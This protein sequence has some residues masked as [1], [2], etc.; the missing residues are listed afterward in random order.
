MPFLGEWAALTTAVCWSI[1]SILFTFV[2]RRTGAFALNLARLSVAAVVLSLLVLLLYGSGWLVH[3]HGR[4]L[5]ALAL[6]GWIGLTLGD[7]AYFHSMRLLGAR[8]A[9]LMMALAPPFTVLLGIPALKELPRALE[10]LGMGLTVAGVA[11]VVLE[12]SHEQV[13]AGHRL[14]GLSLG[15]L[16][17]VGQAA[18]LILSKAG[19]AGGIHPLP[20]TAVRI[21]AGCAGAWLLALLARRTGELG[22]IKSERR[23]LPAILAASVLGPTLGIWL[24]LVAVRYT[25]AGIAATLMSTVPVL[26]LP[27]VVL[28]HHERVSLRAAAGAILAVIGV[29]I[30]FLRP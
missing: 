11:W 8:L 4:D 2:V 22:R 23:I 3:A 29:A 14:R 9:T 26:V 12:R 25:Q 7:W 16:G 5:F 1:T 30:L 18:G 13:P 20:A 24:S 17:S 21:V 27:M 10:L 28:I 19:M 15:V 6:S